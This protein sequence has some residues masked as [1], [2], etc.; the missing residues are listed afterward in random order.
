MK[1]KKYKEKQYGLS[2]CNKI[3]KALLRNKGKWVTM[4]SL[5]R[6]SGSLNVHSRINDLRNK[7]YTVMQKNERDGRVVNSAYMIE[8][9]NG[10]AL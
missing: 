1:Q 6:T 8:P 2:Q 5:S 10:V 7:G 9:L 4:P 3:L